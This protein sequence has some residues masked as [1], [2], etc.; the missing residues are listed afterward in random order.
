MLNNN[1]P[2]R[3]WIVIERVVADEPALVIDQC[4]PNPCDP[5]ADCTNTPEDNFECTCHPGF[6]TSSGVCEAAIVDECDPN[7]CGQNA[8]CTNKEDGGFACACQSGF[9]LNGGVCEA[10]TTAE[11]THDV[12]KT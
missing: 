10:E 6:V 11:T 5:N 1:H 4:D 8:D 2:D 3:R 12:L 9:V 7:P